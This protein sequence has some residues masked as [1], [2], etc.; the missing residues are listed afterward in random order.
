MSLIEYLTLLK[1]DNIIEVVSRD[2]KVK[3]AR[4]INFENSVVIDIDVVEKFNINNVSKFEIIS[5]VSI[6]NRRILNVVFD[7][8]EDFKILGTLYIYGED[9]CEI[10]S[11]KAI[12]NR[13]ISDNE[14]LMF[15][16]NLIQKYSPNYYRK[17]LNIFR[18][19]YGESKL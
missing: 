18:K 7:S 12:L 16:E 14:I 2:H 15:I 4:I 11:I 3:I 1:N 8:Y 17:I 13:R 9:K 5:E 10:I 6:D 19:Y